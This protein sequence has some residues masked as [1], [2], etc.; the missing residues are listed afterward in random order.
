MIGCTDKLSIEA[1]TM[2][3]L[4]LRP[5]SS[6]VLLLFSVTFAQRSVVRADSAAPSRSPSGAEQN[7]DMDMLAS[8]L[9]EKLKHADIKT[10]AVSRFYGKKIGRSLEYRLSDDFTSAFAKNAGD[11]HVLE[12][13]SLIKALQ[14]KS[15]MAIDLDDS[16]VFRSIAVASGAD[17]VIQ[18]SLKLDGKFVE[19]SLKAVNPS[20]EKK[21]AEV[22][23][24]ILVP[25][26]MDDPTDAPVQDPVTG[27][28][29][30]GIGGVTA[31]SCTHC[32]EPQFSSEMRQ[33][34]I[35]QAM[36]VF[37][38]TIRSDGRPADIH[39]VQAAGHGLDENSLAALQ[40]WQFSPAHLPNGT[41]VPS[42]VDIEVSYHQ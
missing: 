30:P 18:G 9:V 11:I 35:S 6:V 4:H 41:A 22:K 37:R 2:K 14:E 23:A 20:T 1:F 28:Y 40:R 33:K 16:L 24:K 25:Q 12:R 7:A 13:A 5:L 34:N 36:N 8:R 29:L 15:W 38:L 10:V 42:R 39:L 21:I 19:F 27:V 3:V 32:P 31:P 26:G 17:A